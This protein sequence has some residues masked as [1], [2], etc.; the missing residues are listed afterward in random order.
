[1]NHPRLWLPV[2]ASC[3]LPLNCILGSPSAIY[4]QPAWDS[5]GSAFLADDGTVSAL[6]DLLLF[7]QKG[8]F[9]QQPDVIC[10]KTEAK[11]SSTTLFV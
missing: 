6:T 10:F 9:I 3:S 4:D 1:M 8:G 2:L 7:T 5:A 11:T